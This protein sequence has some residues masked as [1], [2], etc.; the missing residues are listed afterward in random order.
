[1]EHLTQ[2]LACTFTMAANRTYFHFNLSAR[3][4]NSLRLTSWGVCLLP[5]C[6]THWRVCGVL[7]YQAP[8][9]QS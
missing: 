5:W 3:K 4:R 8:L 7:G 6:V 1:M 9:L 2:T